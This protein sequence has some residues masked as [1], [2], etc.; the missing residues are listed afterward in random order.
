MLAKPQFHHPIASL[1]IYPT[2]ASSNTYC[3]SENQLE[4]VVEDE[5]AALSV[6]EEL[7]GLAV[8]HR[9]LLFVD[10]EESTISSRFCDRSTAHRLTM[11]VPRVRQ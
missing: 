6:G 2:Q 9:P 7:E 11:D 5:E 10:L 1:P 8:V 3:L 4:D